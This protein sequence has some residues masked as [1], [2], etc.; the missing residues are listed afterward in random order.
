ML[1]V[2]LPSQAAKPPT[3]ELP[4]RHPDDT[5][6]P[7]NKKQSRFP[8]R[9]S[10]WLTSYKKEEDFRLGPE[11]RIKPK[12]AENGL[13]TSGLNKNLTRDKTERFNAIRRNLSISRFYNPI[14]PS[15]KQTD[16][17]L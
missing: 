13:V 7:Y 17:F 16:N 14:K 5:T 1:P 11:P 2:W 3:A 15:Q 4:P 12:S 8:L 6:A 9:F 10:F